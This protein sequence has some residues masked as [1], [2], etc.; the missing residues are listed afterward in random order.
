VLLRQ[1]RFTKAIRRLLHGGEKWSQSPVLHRTQ[2]A[3]ETH[4]SAGSI[5]VLAHGH[6]GT[7]PSWKW[8]PHPEFHQAG[9]FTE[10]MHR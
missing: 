5:A 4:L 9:L 8:I 1:N 7:W 3:Y 6:I 10:Q 2:R